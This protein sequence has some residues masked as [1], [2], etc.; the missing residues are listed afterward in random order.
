M[1][2][3]ILSKEIERLENQETIGSL[4]PRKV[5]QDMEMSRYHLPRVVYHQV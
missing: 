5:T 1:S 4:N 2:D 3:K